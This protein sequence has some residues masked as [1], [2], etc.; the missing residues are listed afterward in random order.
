[1]NQDS[2]ASMSLKVIGVIFIVSS[3]VDYVL[4]AIPFQPG[5]REW[6]IAYAAQVVERGIIPLV[7]IAF[8]VIGFW[9]ERAEGAG[10]AKRNPFQDLRFWAFVLSTILGLVFLVVFPLHLNNVRL[11]RA[12]ALQQIREQ[13]SQTEG[14]VLSQLENQNVESEIQQRRSAIGEQI[15]QLISNPEQLQEAL[16]N[17]DVPEQERELLQQFQ[18]NPQAVDQFLNQQF[19]TDNIR[20][21]QITQ[22]RSRQQELESQT[23]TRFTK[24]AVQTGISSLLLSVAYSIIGWTGLKSMGTVGGGRRK[25]MGR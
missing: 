7:G 12:D 2:V 24:L 13:A 16:Q 14:Q 3:L 4:L 15:R 9:M 20:T 1:M 6:Q 17:P 22:I 10:V 25:S 18:D 23:Q 5:S 11:Q 19:S 8:L 21:Q